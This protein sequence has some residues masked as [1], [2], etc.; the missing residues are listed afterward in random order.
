M[1]TAPDSPAAR[2]AKQPAPVFDRE[3]GTVTMTIERWEAVKA[4]VEKLAVDFAKYA[5]LVEKLKPFALAEIERE[6]AREFRRRALSGGR[7]H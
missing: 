4:G 5:A 1:S 6:K 7:R 3:A 2:L